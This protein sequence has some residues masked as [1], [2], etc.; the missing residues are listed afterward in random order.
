MRGGKKKVG[1][2]IPEIKAVRK[3]EGRGDSLGTAFVDFCPPL[4]GGKKTSRKEGKGRGNVPYSH[5][6]RIYKKKEGGLEGE[7]EG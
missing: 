1:D 5:Q 3:K 6:L 7:G 2:R 4:G